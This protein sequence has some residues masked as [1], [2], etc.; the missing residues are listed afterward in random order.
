VR[1]GWAL[2]RMGRMDVDEGRVGGGCV[3]VRVGWVLA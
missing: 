2:V 3:L 1:V